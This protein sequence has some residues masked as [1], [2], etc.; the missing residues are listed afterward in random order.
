MDEKVKIDGD[1]Q[2][3]LDN[4]IKSHDVILFM[5]GTKQVPLCGYSNFVVQV[6]KE[7]KLEF[8]CVDVL[9]N[10]DIRDGIKIYGQWPT[11]PQL[12][13]KG[14]FVGGCDI[15]KQMYNNGKLLIFLQEMSLA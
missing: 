9:D 1:V 4:L 15:V 5:K 6:L 13:I 2:V 14:Q 8:H 7:L 3:Y 12:Y 10:Q 11:I